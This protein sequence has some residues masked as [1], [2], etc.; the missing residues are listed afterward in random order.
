MRRD[1]LA[2]DVR[3]GPRQPAEPLTDTRHPALRDHDIIEPAAAAS[4]HRVDAMTDLG[5]A[6]AHR[7]AAEDRNREKR[8][9]WSKLARFC[10]GASAFFDACLAAEPAPHAED[11]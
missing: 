10:R 9:S 4:R 1:G 2:V 11:V 8:L 3:V 5:P 7:S 6:A